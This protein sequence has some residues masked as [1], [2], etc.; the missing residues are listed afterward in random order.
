MIIVIVTSFP[1]DVVDPAAS[2][3]PQQIN[4]WLADSHSLHSPLQFHGYFHDCSICRRFFVNP[5]YKVLIY[6]RNESIIRPKIPTLQSTVYE[7]IVVFWITSLRF[8]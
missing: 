7:V 2:K 5:K 8:N 3:P 4:Q 1:V 6:M